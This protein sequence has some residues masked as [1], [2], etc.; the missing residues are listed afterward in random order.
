MHNRQINIHFIHI[1]IMKL[2]SLFWDLSVLARA[3]VFSNLS[4]ASRHIGLSQPQLSRIVKK[5]EDELEVQLLDR[6]AKRKSGWT[7]AAM[8]LAEQFSKGSRDLTRQ[9]E[10]AVKHVKLTEIR[11][12]TLEGLTPLAVALAHELIST[13][14]FER[15]DLDVHDIGDLEDHFL[16][17]HYD[18][19]FSF[20]EPGNRKFRFVETLG[21]QRFQVIDTSREIF[22]GSHFEARNLETRSKKNKA[23]K[24]YVISNSLLVRREWLENWGGHGNLPS[25]L[26]RDKS[27]TRADQLV[28]MIGTDDLPKPLWE[29]LLKESRAVRHKL[30]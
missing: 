5:I 7:R 1:K 3:V 28:M 14:N 27:S 30:A 24:K 4:S 20:R 26:Q 13:D 8:D 23:K 12:G 19:I 18:V 2:E 16:R 25:E 22:V 11:I 6:E 15:A 29:I 21:Y 17:G 10:G 9:L